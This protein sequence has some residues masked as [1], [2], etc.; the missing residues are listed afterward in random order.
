MVVN[1]TIGEN[2]FFVIDTINYYRAF[3]HPIDSCKI[4]IYFTYQT[5]HYCHFGIVMS[6]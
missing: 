5:N 4:Y 2:I 3:P 6:N 1:Q